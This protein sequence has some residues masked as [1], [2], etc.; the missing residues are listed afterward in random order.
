MFTLN[1][2]HAVFYLFHWKQ[3]LFHYVGTIEPIEMQM[4]AWVHVQES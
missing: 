1:P 4:A 3:E 2:K